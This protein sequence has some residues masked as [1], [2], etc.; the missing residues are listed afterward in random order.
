M[1]ARFRTR[2][3]AQRIE[4]LPGFEPLVKSESLLVG[5]QGKRGWKDRL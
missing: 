3:G 4:V 2:F 5:H 1:G